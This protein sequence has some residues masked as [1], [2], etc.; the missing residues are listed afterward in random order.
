MNDDLSMDGRFLVNK[1]GYLE[2]CIMAFNTTDLLK[3]RAAAIKL[4]IANWETMASVDV[5][6]EV[7]S[8][9]SILEVEIISPEFIM[10][11]IEQYLASN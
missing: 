10:D 3:I 11:R 2:K 9:L 5:L 7:A 4:D 1:K 6:Y 8:R